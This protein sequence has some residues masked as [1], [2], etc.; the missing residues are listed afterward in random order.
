MRVRTLSDMR[1]GSR[2][3]YEYEGTYLERQEDGLPVAVR[4]LSDMRIGSR[5]LYEYEGTY[6]E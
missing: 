1:M 5:L 6:L 2:L 3:L 4:T